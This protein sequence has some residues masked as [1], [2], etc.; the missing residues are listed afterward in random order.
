MQYMQN[1]I[2]KSKY[3]EESSVKNIFSKKLPI[4]IKYT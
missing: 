2:R 3:Y 4:D 1:D